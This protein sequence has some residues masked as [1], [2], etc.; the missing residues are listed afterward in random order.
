M[1][2]KKHNREVREIWRTFD[3]GDPIK[4]PMVAGVSDRFWV[5]NRNTNPKGVS[6]REYTDNPDLMFEMQAG[7]DRYRRLHVIGDHMMG[8]P[9]EEEEGWNVNI[10]FQNYYEASWFGCKVE[11]PGHEVP[12]AV[13]M[14]NEDNKE[15]LFEKGI[16]DPFSGIMGLGRDYYERYLE[17]KKTYLLDG[18]PVAHIQMFFTGT[19]GPFTIGCELL[20][21][22]QLCVL[23]YE[24]PDYVHQLMNYLTEATILRMKAWR[25]YLDLAEI[26]ES[27]DF[28]DDSIMLLSEEMY[29]E[30]VLPYHKKLLR[31]LSTM[32]VP[33]RMHLCGDATR[34]FQT[35][36]R[37][38]N[39]SS[40]DTGFPVDHGRLVRELG[41]EITILG[42][43]KSEL[44]RAG[45]REQIMEE[46]KRIIQ[47]VRPY[48]KKFILREGNDI[49]PY[50]P[51]ENIAAL[52]EARERYGIYQEGSGQ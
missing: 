4:M 21:A 35:I 41:P 39:I 11:F 31:G 28:A 33:G 34:H 16:P 42:G 36:V 15:L 19:D 49:A 5:M 50:T 25:K 44:V 46:A 29:R 7:F 47:E 26:S 3:A 45:S 27:F 37:E 52:Y 8:Y 23:L 17:R 10:D 24:D 22:A 13:P 18:Y 12:Y 32:E 48:T 40:F 20:G 2:Y 1:D 14:L 43:P 9:E 38:L 51:L 30:F 6:F